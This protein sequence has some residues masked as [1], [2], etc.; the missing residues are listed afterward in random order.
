MIERANVVQRILNMFDKPSYL[1]IGVDEGTTFRTATA[2]RK[3][4]VDP[5]F[6]FVP[7]NMTIGDSSIEYVQA[8]SDRYF[9]EICGPC[10]CFDVA[11]IDGLHTF[12]QTLR[13]LLNVL[14]RLNP[15]GVII[16]DDIL[17]NSYHASLPDVGVAFQVRNYLA[18]RQPE[19]TNDATW[20]GDVFKLAFFIRCFLQPY[21]YATIEEN[22]GQLI[23]W[24]EPRADSYVGQ[25]RVDEIGAL[26]FRHTVTHREVFN[27]LPF[28][29]IVAMVQKANASA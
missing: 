16:I 26:E 19:L 27:L 17:P 7:K 13:D 14:A 23:M 29:Q 22:H 28:E 18:Q 8:T 2:T 25:S 5:N 1:E 24:R 21:S 11:F 20:M 10:E 3:V 12:E 15:R 4:G 6:K 9:G